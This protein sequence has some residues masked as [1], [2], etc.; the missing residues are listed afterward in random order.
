MAERRGAA[1]CEVR[2]RLCEVVFADCQNLLGLAA[3]AVDS[4]AFALESIGKLI[5]LFDV[6]RLAVLR[7]VYCLAYRI[8]AIFLECSLHAH[9]PFRCD[10]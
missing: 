6:S 9:M 4:N 7:E 1:A 10:V 2:M 3:I 8:V 5:G